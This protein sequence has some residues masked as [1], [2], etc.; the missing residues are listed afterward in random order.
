MDT[1]PITA[2]Q[3]RLLTKPDLADRWQTSIRYIDRQVATGR[4][5]KLTLGPRC[6]RFRLTD[7][8]AVEA[9]SRTKT[10]MEGLTGRIA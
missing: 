7:I 6:V 1:K 2:T 9:A 5:S 4:L 8:E 10:I 3:H